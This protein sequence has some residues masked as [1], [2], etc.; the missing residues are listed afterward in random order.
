MAWIKRLGID[1]HRAEIVL[2]EAARAHAAADGRTQAD[3]SDLHAVAAMALRQRR[4]SFMQD[5]FAAQQD[6]EREIA[7]VVNDEKGRA[8]ES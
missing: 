3:P 4:S 6:E 7:S 2:F 5:Y 8:D 1:S